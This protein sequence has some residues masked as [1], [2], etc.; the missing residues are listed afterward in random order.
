LGPSALGATDSTAHPDNYRDN[1][2]LMIEL[3]GS[4]AGNVSSLWV[5]S[6]NVTVQGLVINRFAALG[7]L[8][9]KDHDTIQGN[10]LGTDVTGTQ[11]LGNGGADI[12]GDFE[13]S[14]LL[15]GGTVP[16]ARNLIA[17]AMAV[18]GYAGDGVVLF[19]DPGVQQTV[20]GNFIGTDLSGKNP[21]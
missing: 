4:Y 1:A 7:I 8:V 16:A 10:V 13:A 19:G 9:T 21:L 6:D 11:A 15:I 5:A 2:V 18:P 20:Q 12:Q 14:Q 17:G 3:N